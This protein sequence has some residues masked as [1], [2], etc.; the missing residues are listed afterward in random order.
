MPIRL[1]VVRSLVVFL[2]F[3]A[4][5][6]Q[7]ADEISPGVS[8]GAPLAA[9]PLVIIPILKAADPK[10]V[11]NYLTLKQGLQEKLVKVSEISGGASVNEVQVANR[12]DRPL[13]LLGGELILGGQQD[14]VLSTDAVVEPKSTMRVAVFCVEHGRWQ[15]QGQFSHSGGLAE[16]KLRRTAKFAR[17]QEEVWG[18]V[19]KKT[20]ALRAESSTGTYR[21]L[22]TGNQGK[23]AAEKFAGLKKAFL[24]LPEKDVVGLATAVNGQV[25][26]VDVFANAGLFRAYRE[27]LLESA[28]IDAADERVEPNKEAPKPAAVKEFIDKAEAA[29]PTEVIQTKSGRSVQKKSRD[30]VNSTV[31]L[32]QKPIYKSY[33]DAK[34]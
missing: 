19:A 15:G 25:R 34:Y 20:S 31:D 1:A 8:L 5:S 33:Q 7:G 29:P 16:G 24:A 32:D 17:I 30:V 21:T 13:L 28:F 27:S 22:A 6:A 9:E 10:D 11:S 4:V 3:A 23:K 2:G 14:R 12:S 26:S 18:Q